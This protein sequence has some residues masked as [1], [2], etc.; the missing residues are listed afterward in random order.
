MPLTRVS[1]QA[2]KQLSAPFQFLGRKKPAMEPMAPTQCP[3]ANSKGALRVIPGWDY[4]RSGAKPMTTPK[5]EARRRGNLRGSGLSRWGGDHHGGGGTLQPV[6]KRR[7]HLCKL[8][9]RRIC[10]RSAT[11]T[12]KAAISCGCSA[13]SS[14]SNRTTSR[15]HPACS[16]RDLLRR[17]SPHWSCHP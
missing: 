6:A 3:A 7:A 1:R 2:E 11:L 10:V 16:L 4:V 14:A 12:P 8:A 5:P 13:V 17:S 15:G 9:W